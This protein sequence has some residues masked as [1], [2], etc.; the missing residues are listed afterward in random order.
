MEKKAQLAMFN[1]LTEKGLS[2]K[3]AMTMIN[4]IVV[5]RD[6]RVGEWYWHVN[7]YCVCTVDSVKDD[8]VTVT[9]QDFQHG[10]C[11]HKSSLIGQTCE[12]FTDCLVTLDKAPCYVSELL[13]DW[14]D[15]IDMDIQRG[16]VPVEDAAP[17]HLVIVG[18]AV[19]YRGNNR[20]AAEETYQHCTRDSR[21]GV[22]PYAGAKVDWLIR[23]TTY[24][25]Y[26]PF[27]EQE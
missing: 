11:T 1:A 17:V 18:D 9:F 27:P 14:Q 19:V 2:D 25:S 12:T 13:A 24:R 3:E 15:A 21:N 22:M 26:N 4:R 5:G 7:A 20:E 10:A 23:F 16:W 6:L 8:M